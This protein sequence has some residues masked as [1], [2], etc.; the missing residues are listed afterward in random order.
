MAHGWGFNPA[1]DTACAQLRNSYGDILTRMRIAGCPESL[2][3]RT[4]GWGV[5]AKISR[6]LADNGLN[7]ETISADGLGEKGVIT[8]TTDD[9]NAALKALTNAGFKSVSDNALIVRLLGEPGTLAKLVERFKDTGID[10]QSLPILD[11]QGNYTTVAISADGR[12][13]AES[14]VGKDSIS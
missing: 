14:L 11:L 2:S 5:I 13:K 1:I 7:I 12:A 6:V 4:T 3:W 9:Y 10:I 8:L